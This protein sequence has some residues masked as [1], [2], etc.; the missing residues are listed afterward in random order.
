MR[1][2][3]LSQLI[4]PWWRGR[5]GD[6][7]NADCPLLKADVMATEGSGWFNLAHITTKLC[8]QCFAWNAECDGCGASLDREEGGLKDE[9]AAK[10]WM[11]EHFCIPRF[12]MTPA[13]R[14]AEPAPRI[15]GQAAL[16]AVEAT[17]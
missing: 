11:N 9:A 4:R 7:V 14:P 12:T 2:T 1:S 6:H 3:D 16:F 17:R 5:D 13:I 15:D 8:P 10:K